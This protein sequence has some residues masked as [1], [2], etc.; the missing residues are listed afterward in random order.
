MRAA[1]VHDDHLEAVGRIIQRCQRAKT[2]FQLLR[3]GVGGNNK[4]EEGPGS[5]RQI[6]PGLFPSTVGQRS[7]ERARSISPA[8]SSP[9]RTNASMMMSPEVANFK[10]S[11]K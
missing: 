7:R 2:G 10:T 5:H 8:P 6:S 11:K 3:A 4:R 1:V 9:S